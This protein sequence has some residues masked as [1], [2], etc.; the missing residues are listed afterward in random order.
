MR[1]NRDLHKQVRVIYRACRRMYGIEHTQD[2]CLRIF[3]IVFPQLHKLRNT[4]EERAQVPQIVVDRLLVVVRDWNPDFE[5]KDLCE[6]VIGKLQT[7]QDWATGDLAQLYEDIFPVAMR[8]RKLTPRECFRL[9]G[10][11]DK[12][13]DKLLNCGVS[14]SNCYKLAGNSIVVDVMEAIFRKMFVDNEQEK[15]AGTQLSLF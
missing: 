8:I 2:E 3:E 4:A 15:V 9:M 10:V 14:N 6:L 13:I 1:H 7:P 11:V 12:D 5:L